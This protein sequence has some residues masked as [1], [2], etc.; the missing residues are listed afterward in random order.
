MP[1]SPESLLSFIDYA[2]L[3]RV[4]MQWY[5]VLVVSV[6]GVLS[7]AS[8]VGQYQAGELFRRRPARVA[9]RPMRLPFGG[10]HHAH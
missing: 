7:L 8:L 9:A 5:L 1:P 3:L 2:D 4:A 6:F 10:G